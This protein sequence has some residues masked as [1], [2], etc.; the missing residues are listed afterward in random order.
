MKVLSGM[1]NTTLVIETGDSMLIHE[2]L[3]LYHL[4]SAPNKTNFPSSY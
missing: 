2:L 4:E 3:R 1:T